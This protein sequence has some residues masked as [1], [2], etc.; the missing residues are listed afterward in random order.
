MGNLTAHAF[1][2]VGEVAEDEGDLRG[3]RKHALITKIGYTF[4]EI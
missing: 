4:L 1:S 2:A 3:G